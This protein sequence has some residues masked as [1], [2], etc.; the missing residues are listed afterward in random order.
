[1]R[2]QQGQLGR[3]A[4]LAQFRQAVVTRLAH[5]F[6]QFRAVGDVHRV[7]GAMGRSGR[8]APP[9]QVVAARAPAAT[10]VLT[11]RH[12]QHARVV[13]PVDPVVGPPDGQLPA[14]VRLG[15]QRLAALLEGED[16]QRAPHAAREPRPVLEDA[17][18]LERPRLT[19]T[20]LVLRDPAAPPALVVVLPDVGRESRHMFGDPLLVV[21]VR[22]MGTQGAAPVIRAAGLDALAA[23]AED[24][25]PTR[26]QPCQIAAED[27][28]VV[29]RIRKFH[30]CAS[31]IEALLVVRRRL[32]RQLRCCHSRRGIRDQSGLLVLLG[33]LVRLFILR[34]F[35]LWHPSRV[36]RPHRGTG[37]ARPPQ[38][39]QHGALRAVAFRT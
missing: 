10:V 15:L 38:T 31:E 28:L 24:A 8:R 27:L 23:A 2:C 6:G 26:G 35:R 16:V 22:E 21:L 7:P 12:L 33:L 20:V 13:R 25:V 14:H 29:R 18:A 30:P 1:M 17:R 32:P 34:L 3:Q 19:L 5:Q 39:G 36:S 9:V 4:F 11:D 37:P